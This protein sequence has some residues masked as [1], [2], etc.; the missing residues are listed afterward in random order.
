[1]TRSRIGFTSMIRHILVNCAAIF[2]VGA[3][4][5]GYDIHAFDIRLASYRDIIGASVGELENTFG[6]SNILAV[7][8]PMHD[9]ETYED[10]LMVSLSQRSFFVRAKDD[11]VQRVVFSSSDYQTD[12]GVSVG[13]TYCEVL[14]AY[15]NSGFEFSY[16]DGGFL[17]LVDQDK[18]FL[19]D[20]DIAELFTGQFVIEG[21]P[22]K[23]SRSLCSTELTSIEL[24]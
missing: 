10:W 3:S 24:R 23:R 18:G 19:F 12:K 1:M 2:L 20:F 16:E 15:P 6:P 13:Q 5:S 8:L 21:P 4:C 14:A 17:R 7:K 22:N 9:P 11:A